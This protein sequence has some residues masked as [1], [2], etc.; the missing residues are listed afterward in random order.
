M[1]QNKIVEMICIL[2][3]SGSMYGKEREIIEGYNKMLKEQ[4]G[5]G[6]KAC[7]T[8][9]LFSDQ[10]EIICSHALIESAEILDESIYYVYG[11]TALFDA[12]GLA[13]FLVDKVVKESGYE[14]KEDVLV[15][16]ITDG[17]ENASQKYDGGQIKQ[18]LE[19]KQIRGWVIL[20]FSPDM[21]AVNMARQMGIKTGNTVI[22]DENEE[23]IRKSCQTASD[24]FSEMRSIKQ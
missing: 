6:E 10:C 2:D 22:Y 21:A 9:V 17:I 3:R 12:I 8:T 14:D 15:V 20:F 13:F 23:G 11:N 18:I 19:E 24:M 7:V 1:S 16:I 5:K 4:K